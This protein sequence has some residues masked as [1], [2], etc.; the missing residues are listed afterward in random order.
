MRIRELEREELSDLWSIDRAEV[1]ENIYY[2][3]GGRLVLKPEH[4]DMKGWPDGEPEHYAPMLLDCFDRGGKACGAFDGTILVGASVL[5]SRLIGD[6]DQLQLKFLHVSQKARKSGLG[7]RLFELAASQARELG[8]GRLYISAT[9]TENTVNFYLHL[10]C[11][12]T[13]HINEALFQLEPKDI[14]LEFQL[15]VP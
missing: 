14:H 10:G 11:A 4:Y 5:E 2:H 12:V 15:P 1:V 6:R 7:R 9:P 13:A 8:A 3:E